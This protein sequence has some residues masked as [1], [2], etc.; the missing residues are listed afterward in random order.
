MT[1]S[2]SAYGMFRAA[3]PA[4]GASGCTVPD[5]TPGTARTAA[6]NPAFR[7]SRIVRA[8]YYAADCGGRMES[9]FFG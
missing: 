3:A 5:N 7:C 9:L 2:A 4:G 1:G 6:A 8:I